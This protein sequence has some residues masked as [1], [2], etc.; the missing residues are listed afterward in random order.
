MEGFEKWWDSKGQRIDKLA[1]SMQTPG[2][3]S[4][5]DAMKFKELYIKK[6]NDMERFITSKLLAKTDFPQL[7]DNIKMMHEEPKG[8]HYSNEMNMINKL[9][10]GVNAKQYREQHDIE[11]GK[12]I[13]LFLTAS[14]I[15]FIEK[16]QRVDVGMVVAIPDYYDRQI[17]LKNYY[18][19][20]K[21]DNKQ[22]VN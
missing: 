11:N 20:I 12:S 9:V 19:M 21:K 18:N 4:K 7:T 6:F 1:I 8:Y 10:L 2:G 14:E 13:R 15:E 17:A 3:K 5:K 16:L 22:I